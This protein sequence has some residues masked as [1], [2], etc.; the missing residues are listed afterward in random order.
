[1]KVMNYCTFKRLMKNLKNPAMEDAIALMKK[2]FLAN[3]DPIHVA[4]KDIEL[5]NLLAKEGVLKVTAINT[6][7]MASSLLHSLIMRDITNWQLPCPS[8]PI[9]R[10]G[11][12][13][14]NIFKTLKT[15]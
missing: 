15:V 14:L 1:D 2:K 4:G 8:N 12:R 3:P 6:F 9:P 11:D 13:S 10:H 7:V 5:S